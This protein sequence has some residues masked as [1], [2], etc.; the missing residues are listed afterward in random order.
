[1]VY[2][3]GL[4]KVT[5]RFDLLATGGIHEQA[6]PSIWFLADDLDLPT[7]WDAALLGAAQKANDSW[8][9]FFPSSLFESSVSLQSV[10]ATQ[11]GTDLKTA[12][13]QVYIDS[14]PWQGTASS[15]SLPWN[16]SLCISLYTYTPG[17]FIADA[18]SRRGRFYL[19]PMSVDALADKSDGNL[20]AGQVSAYLDAM[21]SVVGAIA[22]YDLPTTTHA[23]TPG[24]LSRKNTHLYTLT[25]WRGDTK[26]DSQRR[27][28]K[29]VPASVVTTPY[30]V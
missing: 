13:E 26:M 12:H 25:D 10:L 3:V 11:Y 19:P 9:S 18:R 21:N 23:M 2:P 15:G 4:V 29:K 24:V 5:F 16:N 28:T 7:D 17:T 22:T 8:Q 20:G 27:R 14:T 6:E 1:M 30:T